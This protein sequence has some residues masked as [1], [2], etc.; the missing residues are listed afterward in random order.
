MSLLRSGLGGA[1]E[2]EGISAISFAA[3]DERKRELTGEPRRGGH[4]AKP[5]LNQLAIVYS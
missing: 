3:A 2:A 1:A 5:H 4:K